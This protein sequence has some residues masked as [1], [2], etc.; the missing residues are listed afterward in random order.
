MK[1]DRKIDSKVW[2]LPQPSRLPM[3]S[4]GEGRL[5]SEVGAV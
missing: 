2:A 5:Y 3:Q 1:I 4:D